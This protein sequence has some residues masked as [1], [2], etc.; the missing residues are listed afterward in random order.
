MS[1]RRLIPLFDRVLVRRLVA[2]KQSAGGVLLPEA[3]GPKLNE[4]QVVATGPGARNSAGEL[5]PCS[6]AAGDKVLLPEYGGVEIKLGD[7][8]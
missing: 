4:G 8:E 7:E 1:A 5:V 3:A 6:V 2:P